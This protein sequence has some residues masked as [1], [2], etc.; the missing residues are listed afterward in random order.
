MLTQRGAGE[1][2]QV[3]QFCYYVK[4]KFW[5]KGAGPWPIWPKGKYAAALDDIFRLGKCD[6]GVSIKFDQN[7]TREW[8]RG[9]VSHCIAP[10]RLIFVL[11][12][13]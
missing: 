11:L 4:K 5:P 13:R 9:C 10:R 7:V 12:E 3:F 8:P 1:P 6:F 2:N